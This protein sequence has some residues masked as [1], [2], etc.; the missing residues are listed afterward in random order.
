MDHAQLR[1]EDA[2]A[3]RQPSNAMVLYIHHSLSYPVHDML[4]M[5]HAGCRHARC[6]PGKCTHSSCTAATIILG[7]RTYKNVVFPIRTR[8]FEDR[9]E[10]I[11]R[12][13]IMRRP[14]MH[15]AS[16]YVEHRFCLEPT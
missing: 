10:A 4:C 13:L 3:A 8:R 6:I 5:A 11:V 9:C 16:T 7:R 14:S 12:Y 1:L 15:M 2:T